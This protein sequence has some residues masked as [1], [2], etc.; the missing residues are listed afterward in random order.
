MEKMETLGAIDT[1]TGGVRA[2]EVSLCKNHDF[3]TLSGG[4]DCGGVMSA[5]RGGGNAI[6]KRYA[7]IGTPYGFLHNS[8]GDWRFWKSASGARRAAAKY[9]AL[10]CD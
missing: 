5:W 9:R 7:V 3:L 8:A 1:R 4:C 10:L 6:V 2:V